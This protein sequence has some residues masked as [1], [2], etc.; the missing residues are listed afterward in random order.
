M[1]QRKVRTIVL[2]M[3]YVLIIGAIIVS[4]TFLNQSLFKE[5]EDLSYSVSTIDQNEVVPVIGEVTLKPMKPYMGDISINVDYYNKDD[6]ENNQKLSLILYQNTYMPNTGILYSNGEIFDV[7]A[8]LDGTI[9][10]ISDNDILG[11]VIEITHSNN[12]ITYYYSLSEVTVK[13]GDEVKMGTV[14]G[15]SGE[16]KIENRNGSSLLFE[17]YYNGKAID[18]QSF[19]ELD[20]TKVE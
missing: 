12:I 18:P 13:V 15:K 10:N 14:I 5:S 8:S 6:D 9:K 4:I 3:L 16:N 1:N 2:P 11:K 19:Y 20:L 7:V 17:V